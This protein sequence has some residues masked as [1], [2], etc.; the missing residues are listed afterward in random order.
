MASVGRLGRTFGIA[1]RGQRGT[2][3]APKTGYG[4][5]NGVNRQLCNR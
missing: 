3:A 2:P 5:L 4:Q 1:K